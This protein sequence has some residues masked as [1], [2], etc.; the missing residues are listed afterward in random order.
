MNRA[1]D[2]DLHQSLEQY[3]LDFDFIPYLDIV[4]N[5][6]LEQYVLDFDFIPYLDIKV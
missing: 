1:L 6:S 3:V 4:L 2:F 5:Q